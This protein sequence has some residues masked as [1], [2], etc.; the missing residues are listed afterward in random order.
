MPK[1]ARSYIPR[2]KGGPFV[3]H[4]GPFTPDSTA[5]ESV[6]AGTPAER[7]TDP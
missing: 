5:R 7:A 2:P 6:P 4:P 1:G 3:P